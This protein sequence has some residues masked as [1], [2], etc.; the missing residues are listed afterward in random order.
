MKNIS[1]YYQEA[2]EI[3]LKNRPL[4]KNMPRFLLLSYFMYKL[5][6]IGYKIEIKWMIKAAFVSFQE[7]LPSVLKITL[8][9]IKKK[10]EKTPSSP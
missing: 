5:R 1:D 7:W 9:K 3:K 6:K 10:Y 8:Q 2:I 4:I